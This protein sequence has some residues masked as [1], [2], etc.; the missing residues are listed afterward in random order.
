VPASM[1]AT[2]KVSGAAESLADYRRRVNDLL[3]E[4]RADPYRELHTR[5]RLE[6]RFKVRRGIPFPA[7]VEVS[8]AFPDLLVEVEWES[9]EQGTRGSATIQSGRLKQQRSEPLNRAGGVC[10]D[11]HIDAAANLQLAFAC[12]RIRDGLWI[13]YVLSA[14]QHAFFEIESGAGGELVL[15]A[16][17]AVEPRWAE[18]W[19]VH[20]PVHAGVADASTYAELD[21]RVS[22]PDGLLQALENLALD[23]AEEWIWFDETPRE[24]TAVE[25]SRYETYGY[26]VRGA[27]LKSEKIKTALAGR[28][29]GGR[30]FSSLPEDMSWI[31]DLLA[32]HWRGDAQN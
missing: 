32:A 11:V 10:I 31:R 17:D 29:D 8:N 16:S 25:R 26:G 20:A 12:R 5:G 14:A 28:E 1:N 13:G 23:F 9:S 7:F 27:N 24:E 22:I 2:V 18:K 19:I 15:Y 30:G 3:A 6:Y 21:P 4:E